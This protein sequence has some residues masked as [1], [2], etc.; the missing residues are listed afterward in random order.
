MK[1]ESMPVPSILP[2]K[3]VLAILVVIVRGLK[4]KSSLRD[5]KPDIPSP[6]VALSLEYVSHALFTFEFVFTLL[7][8]NP[9]LLFCF[10]LLHPPSPA[11]YTS[12]HTKPL[13]NFELKHLQ[14]QAPRFTNTS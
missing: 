12:L 8:N 3:T 14:P 10:P 7:E 13:F 11:F 5:S 2:I 4:D 6:R 9:S 1:G